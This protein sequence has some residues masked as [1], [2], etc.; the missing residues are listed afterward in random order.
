MRTFTT[1]VV[2]SNLAACFASVPA[3]PAQK[4]GKTSESVV[5]VTAKADKTNADGKQV[6]TIT[7]QAEKDWHTYANPVGLE[8]LESAQTVVTITSKNK[9]EDVK[10]DYP[11]GKLHKDEV[12]GNYSVYEGKVT[13]K[14]TVQR[15]KGDTGPLQISVKFQACSD[16]QKTCL[17]PATVK[18]T[19]E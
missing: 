4:G 15:A 6:V 1:I 9:P 3:T 17:V 5:K 16:V 13:I 14:A 11:K 12:V 10:I 8:D 19:V 18:L 7:M 2:L